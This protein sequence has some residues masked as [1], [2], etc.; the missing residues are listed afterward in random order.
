MQYIFEAARE[1]KNITRLVLSTEDDEI[2]SVGR[3]MGIEVPF[4]RP[5]ELATDNAPSI[6]VIKHALKFFTDTGFLPDGV[7][8]LQ[9]TNPFLTTKTIDSV[10]ELWLDTGCDSVT[11]VGEIK[12][13]HPYIARRLEKNN[14]IRDFCSI[15]EGAVV[16][17]RQK[18]EKAYYLT[19]GVYL[20]G[21]HLLESDNIDGHCLGSDSRAV[22]VN[23]IE[24]VDIN[25]EADFKYAE[26]LM[27]SGMIK[28]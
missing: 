21:K 4:K 12:K 22:V 17:P 16:G 9:P 13:A 15:P 20:R 23:E 11:T 2:A 1:S 5:E 28:A 3:D 14:V 27:S 8:S 18:R 26:F 10:I 24:S 19:G 7:I 25:T 6:S